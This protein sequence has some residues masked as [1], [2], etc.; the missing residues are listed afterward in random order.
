M[1]KYEKATE[2]LKLFGERE[3]LFKELGRDTYLNW[4]L[5]KENKEIRE[6]DRKIREIETKINEMEAQ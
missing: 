1:N 2:I 5:G 4:I 6:F 3:S